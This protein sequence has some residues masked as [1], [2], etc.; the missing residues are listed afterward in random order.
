MLNRVAMQISLI[1][2]ATIWAGAAVGQGR[3]LDDGQ[4]GFEINGSL[5]SGKDYTS[6][7]ASFGYS[8]GAK[9]DL[10]LGVS[11]SSFDDEVIGNDGSGTEFTPF[12]VATIVKPTDT[13]NVGVELT[14]A[15]GIAS[16]SSDA[17]DFLDWDMS[18]KALTAGGNLYFRIQSSPTLEIYPAASV[19]YVSVTAKLEDSMGNSEDEDVNE[20]AFGAAVSFLFNKKVHVTPAFR[21][22]DG[23]TSFA[24]S[25]GLVVPGT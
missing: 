14:A 6:L 18:A 17:L 5:W 13:S 16:F 4:N 11:R 25:I 19:D 3:F 15:Y 23:E 9:F 24:I 1:L 8:F 21:S 7:G 2:L 12:A 20:V 10:G 22:F